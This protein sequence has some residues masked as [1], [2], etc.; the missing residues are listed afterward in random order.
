[1]L[2]SKKK[3]FNEKN[4]DIF[5]TVAGSARFSQNFQETA[6]SDATNMYPAFLVLII[7]LSY[8]LLRSV[9]A[10]LLSLIVIFLSILPSMGSAGWLEYQVLPPLIIAPIIILTIALAHAIHILSIALSNMNE[11]MQKDKAIIESKKLTLRQY[12]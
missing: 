11:G 2:K 9:S 10:S 8:I 5:V 1:L 7:I 6:Q 12:S 4:P 3:L